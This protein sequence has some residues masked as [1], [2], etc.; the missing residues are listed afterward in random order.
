MVCFKF[1][2]LRRVLFYRRYPMSEQHF[3]P[4]SSMGKYPIAEGDIP[5][6]GWQPPYVYAFYTFK[7]N[8]C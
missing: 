1:V 2:D 8:H 7:V 3:K 6:Y 4:P 5:I